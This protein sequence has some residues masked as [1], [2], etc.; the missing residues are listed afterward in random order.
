MHIYRANL[1]GTFYLIKI[2]DNQAKIKMVSPNPGV[3]FF[4]W[5]VIP[6]YKLDERLASGEIR[7][8]RFNDRKTISLLQDKKKEINFPFLG[9]IDLVEKVIDALA[10]LEP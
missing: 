9:K 1:N 7:E 8:L 2:E 4:D 6:K 5:C 3:Y 10:Q